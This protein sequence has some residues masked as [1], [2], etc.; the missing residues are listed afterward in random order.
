MLR[1]IATIIIAGIALVGCGQQAAAPDGHADEPAI[2]ETVAGNEE[3]HRITLTERAAERLG[4]EIAEVTASGA[5]QSRVPYSAVIYDTAGAAWA[6]IVDGAP[7]VFVRQALTIADIVKSEAGDYAVLSSG[8]TA[9]M[10]VVSVGVAE[11][12]GAEF[13]VGH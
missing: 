3:L 1:T 13:E 10:S 7:N 11:L 5:G 12:F 6:Y 4:I 8:P 2:V 9:G